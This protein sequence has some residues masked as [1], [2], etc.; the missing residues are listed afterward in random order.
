MLPCK[1]YDPDKVF[2]RFKVVEFPKTFVQLS[3]SLDLD[4][5]TNLKNSAYLKTM[6]DGKLMKFD[7]ARETSAAHRAFDVTQIDERTIK[8]KFHPKNECIAKAKKKRQDNRF[9]FDLRL[10]QVN[11]VRCCNDEGHAEIGR[12]YISGQ[13]EVCK[14]SHCP[15]VINFGDVI[16]NQ[17]VTKHVRIRNDSNIIIAKISIPRVTSFQFSPSNFYIAPNSSIR[18][19]I[20]VKPTCL[21]VPNGFTLQIRNPHGSECDPPES[22]DEDTNFISYFINYK[23]NISYDKRPKEVVV[24]SLHKLYEQLPKYTYVDEELE[25]RKKKLNIGKEYLNICKLRYAKQPIIERFA[26][27]RDKC[28]LDVLQKNARLDGNF[29]KIVKGKATTYDLF[30]VLFLP[31]IIN[32]GKVALSTYGESEIT[33]KNT[34]KYEISVKFLTDDYVLYSEKKLHTVLLKLKPSEETK[35]T[36]FCLGFVEGSYNGTMEYIIDF[37]YR[38]KHP[39]SLETGYPLLVLPETH[40]KFGMVS[41]DSFITLVPFRIYNHFNVPVNFTWDEFQPDTPFEIMPMSGSVPRHGCKICTV[42]YVCKASKT[43]VHEVDLISESLTTRRIPI[44]LSVVT[45]KLSI[46]FLQLSVVFKDIPLNLKTIEKVKLENSSREIALFHVVEPLI[47]GITIE[48]MCGTIRP[49]MIVAFDIIV[50]ISCVMEFALDILVRIN[51]KENVVLPISGNVVE[52]KIVI[53]PKHIYMSRLPCFM[54]TYVPVTIQNFGMVKAEVDVVDTGD[55][56]IFDVYVTNGNEKQRVLNF[57]VEGGQSKIVYIKVYDIFRREYEMYIPF[58]VNGLL[59]PP[60][61]SS[62]STELHHYVGKYEHLYDNIAKVKLKTVHKDIS[63]CRIV[64]VITVPWIEFSVDNFEFDYIPR[65]KNSIEFNMKN[66]SKYYL[67]VSVVTTKLTPHFTLELKAVEESEV[68]LTETNIK[69]ELDLQKEASFNLTFHPKGHGKFTST[70][71]LFLDKNM[72]IPYYNLTFTGRRETPLMTPSTYRVIFPPCP[73]EVQIMR[74]ITLEMEDEHS[75]DSLSCACKDPNLVVEYLDHNVVEKVDKLCTVITVA[76]K[77][78][79]NVPYIGNVTLNFN[80]ECGSTCDVQQGFRRD[81]YP[82]IPDTFHAI[83]PTLSNCVSTGKSRGINVS[84]LTFVRRIAGPLMK[85]VRK[86]AVQGVDE[87]FKFVKEIHDT[88]REVMVLLQSRG[89]NLWALQPK[90]LLSHEQYVIFVNN[91]TPKC[92]ADIVLTKQLVEDVK[93]FDR[94]NKQSWFDFI[95]QIYKVFVLD[96]CF[97]DCICVSAQP[98]DIVKIL[99]DWFNEQ[100]L[101]QHRNLRGNIKP[102]KH[103][104]NLTTDLSDGIALSCAIMNYCPFL[105]QHFS[106]YCEV[107]EQSR[108]GDIINNACLI[109]DAMHQLRLHFPLSTEDFSSPNFLQMLFLS[110]HLYVILPMFKPKG[111]IRFNPPLLRSS[112]RQ[113]AIAPISQETLI[114]SFIILNNTQNNFLVEK[115]PTGENGKKMFLNVRYTANFVNDDSCILLVHGYNKTRIFDTYIIFLLFGEVGSLS[116][117]RK[118]KVTGPLY[119]P[120]KVDVQVSSPFTTPATF[121]VYLTD[122]EPS[123]PVH[124]DDDDII[125]K[126]RFYL[127]RLNLIDREITLP[128]APKENSQDAIEYKL[129]LLMICLSTNVGNSWIWFSSDIGQFFIR[130]TSQPRWDL[131]VDSLQAKLRTWPLD[132]CS[133]GEACECYRTTVLMIPHRNDLMLKALRYALVEHASDTMMQIFDQLIESVTGK[134]ILAMLLE[135]GG[136]TMSDVQ[137]ILLTNN[138][139]RISSRALIPRI[140]RVTLTQHS[141]AMLALPVTIPAD[142]IFDKYT[143]TLTSD[144]GMDIRTYRIFFIEDGEN[145]SARAHRALGASVRPDAIEVGPMQLLLATTNLRRNKAAA[146]RGGAS[147]R[148]STLKQRA[149][150]RPAHIIIQNMNFKFIKF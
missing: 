126:P 20:S 93:L 94:L 8:I 135:E 128:G 24:Q 144:C 146:R 66:I 69:F 104:T 112:T 116:P 39:Y 114:Y 43:K 106:V 58:K 46:K 53:Q 132:P 137:H 18:V 16:I 10:I 84:F 54:I 141:N 143:V 29:C 98:R 36:V 142:E 115:T 15:K 76:L 138:T 73:L 150:A 82:T 149:P 75:L 147:H 72:A 77:V 118:C 22:T 105:I 34:T 37:A 52:P 101:I 31:L 124:L 71:V 11:D 51:N 47:P 1:N 103:I 109:I 110:I 92:N 129:H 28:Y 121:R 96:S 49:K 13:Y 85:H 127:R 38:G 97:F 2:H 122:T 64:G 59:G 67:Y 63:Y 56:N 12:Y 33:I 80:H 32:F 30:Q 95:L 3:T 136:T 139:F 26:T 130:V 145:A 48:P 87:T 99:L 120:N 57:T 27:G 86:I 68:I 88:Y 42:V 133:C 125:N 62:L 89:G 100:I 131:P 102:V 25:V 111:S 78:F 60:D 19:T 134:L 83:S 117:V 50:K 9:V 108:E 35:L 107:Q 7:K 65:G 70:A 21:K 4:V 140:D 74:V 40:L 44:E 5:E 41:S 81:L 23:I 91:V 14:I 113:V 17:K 90:Y 148:P 6:C 119:R 79:S 61:H 55:D 45:R 123:I